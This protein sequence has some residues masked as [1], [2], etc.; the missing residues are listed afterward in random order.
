MPGTDLTSP[1]DFG[2]GYQWWLP[3]QPEGDFMAVGVYNQF[4]FV[5]PRNG[6]VIAKTSANP[7]YIE[8]E[9]ISK[10]QHAAFFRAIAAKA[11]GNTP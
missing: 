11:V 9:N 7:H 8:D 1:A 4:I 3:P 6:I 2:Y 5:S 10:P